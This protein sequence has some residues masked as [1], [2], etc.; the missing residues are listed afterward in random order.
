MN[1]IGLNAGDNAATLESTQSYFVTITF[2]Y[3]H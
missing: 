1:Y 2:N 3:Y